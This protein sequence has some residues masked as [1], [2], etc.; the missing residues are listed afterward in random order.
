MA[1]DF[2]SLIA[3]AAASLGG[4]FV[5]AFLAFRKLRREKAF[6]RQL[7]WH[8]EIADNLYRLASAMNVVVVRSRTGGL[9]PKQMKIMLRE[10]DRLAITGQKA[11]L[12]ATRESMI[13]VNRVIKDMKKAVKDLPRE[14]EEIESVYVTAFEGMVPMVRAAADGLA[15]DVRDH[16]GLP[17][18]AQRQW[19]N[20]WLRFRRRGSGGIT[21]PAPHQNE[22]TGR[23]D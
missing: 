9:R 20:W 13:R 8:E 3:S 21:R 17:S 4:S 23:T 7:G 5:G 14:G 1:A 12:Y 18:T 22:S 16:L 10:I 19:K 2:P 6:E 11:R 15:D